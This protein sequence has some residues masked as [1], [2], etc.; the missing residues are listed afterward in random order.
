LARRSCISGRLTVSAAF[1][2]RARVA[3]LA[4]HHGADAPEV[5]EARRALAA[6]KDAAAVRRAIDD[7]VQLARAA[8]IVRAAIARRKLAPHDLT[9]PPASPST[10]VSADHGEGAAA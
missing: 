3:A 4:R 7:P 6:A 9:R 5:V 2:H 1:H 10:A 8:R